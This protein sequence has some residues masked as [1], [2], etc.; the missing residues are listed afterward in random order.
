M[1][2]LESKLLNEREV[3]A[4]LGVSLSTVRK[5]RFNDPTFPAAIKV[6]SDVVRFDA[7]ALATWV[8]SRA[9]AKRVTQ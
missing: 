9:E 6:T 4:R 1:R 2:A 7:T 8:A 5:L 3:A